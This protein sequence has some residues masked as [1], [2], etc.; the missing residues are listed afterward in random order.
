MQ[1]KLFNMLVKEDEITWQ[2]IIHDMIKANELDPWDIDISLLTKRYIEMIKKL[3][4]ANFFISGKVLLASGIMLRI[5]SDKLVNEGIAALDS[6]MFPSDELEELDE[7]KERGR[8]VLNADPKLTI[9]T[10]QARKRRVN[11]DDLISALERAL[12][13]NERKILRM[14]E[15]NRIPEGLTVPV[16]K[17]DITELIKEVYA[18]IKDFFIK[19]PVITFTELVGSEKREDKIAT[20]IPLLH[21]ATQEKIDLEQSEH[22]GEIEIKMVNQKV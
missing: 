22:F 8:I 12:E 4:V 16:I 5:K 9:K 7:F 6:I 21:L 10:P 11:I 3:Q 20:F 18:K 15:M 2:T 13:V 17:K 19:K 1:D 14:E